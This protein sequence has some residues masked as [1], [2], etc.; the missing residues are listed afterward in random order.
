M[1]DQKA[2][3]KRWNWI[4]GWLT[5]ALH[6]CIESLDLQVND[7]LAI[8]QLIRAYSHT[9]RNKLTSLSLN[10]DLMVQD[11]EIEYIFHM[12]EELWG[13]DWQDYLNFFP[14]SH[15][16]QKLLQ[17]FHFV[18]AFYI[19][20]R[21]L[22]MLLDESELNRIT[23]K[24]KEQKRYQI[25]RKTLRRCVFG[26][27]N[28]LLTAQFPEMLFAMGPPFFLAATTC[29]TEVVGGHQKDWECLRSAPCRLSHFYR[30]VTGKSHFCEVIE[31]ALIATRRDH[32]VK[33]LKRDKKLPPKTRAYWYDVL[34]HYSESIR[35]NPLWLP[36]QAKQKPYYWNRSIRWFTS[37]VITGLLLLAQ[38]SGAPV[39]SV[40]KT[41]AKRELGKALGGDD[42]FD[43]AP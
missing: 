1:N 24:K 43:K 40:W 29:R 10:R 2:A 38:R 20:E 37:I 27:Q 30:T 35:Y 31:K 5:A 26:S 25:S 19:I 41:R 23:Y 39:G 12:E 22:K 6:A 4:N 32:V 42:R 34:W 28:G 13:V 14:P 33:S 21:C 16:Q 8:G 7:K 9:V 36:S 18:L 15:Y 11:W 17:T 3:E